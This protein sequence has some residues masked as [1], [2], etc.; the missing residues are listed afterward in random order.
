[1]SVKETEEFVAAAGRDLAV[2]SELD[3]L[4][5]G[6]S[7]LLGQMAATPALLPYMSSITL[8]QRY[9][10]ETCGSVEMLERSSTARYANHIWRLRDVHLSKLHGS[11]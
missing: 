2:I 8:L 1:M 6:E 9:D 4:T 5:S 7:H 10:L 11:V 3:W